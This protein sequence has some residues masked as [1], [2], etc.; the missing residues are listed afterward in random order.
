MSL[1]YQLREYELRMRKEG[2][3]SVSS[4]IEAVPADDALP[5]MYAMQPVRW[6]VNLKADGT[7]RD[8]QPR[9]SGKTK[10]KDLGLP[11]AAPELVRAATKAKLLMDNAEYVLGLARKEG[12]KNTL[13]RHEAFRAL[14]LAAAEATDEPSVRAVAT[15]LDGY[16][17]ET[18]RAEH[19]AAYPDFAPDTNVTFAV[20]G[21]Y[22]LDLTRV[23]QFWAE[24]FTDDEA[25]QA[26][27]LITGKFGPVMRIEPVK[28]KGIL[29]GQMAGMNFISAN[30]QAFESYG[31]R[32]S[33]IAPVRL[34][35]AEE[36]ARGLNRL[37]ADPN[38]S[39]KLGGVTYAF[40]T[41]E[42]AV[43]LVSKSLK[44]PP[45]GLSKY[46]AAKKREKQAR[47]EEVRQSLWSLLTGQLPTLK[48]GAAFYAAGFT[49]SGSRIAVRT[50]LS[51]TVQDAVNHLAD[52]FGAQSL[53]PI[54]PEDSKFPDHETFDL[55]ALVGAMYRDPSKAHIAP[56]V[57]A[58]MQF[59]LSGQPLPSVFLVRL[60]A[61]SRADT[62]RVTRPRAVLTKMVLLS[63]KE[64]G[65]QDD[66]LE[67]LDTSRP[68]PAYHLGRLLAVLDDIQSS[69][70]KANTTLVD[71]FYGAMSTTPYAVVGRLIQ[72]SQAHLQKLRKDNEG[73][74]FAKQREL[75]DVMTRL[76]DIPAKPLTTPQQ[77]L[78]ALGYYHQRAEI[79]A[80]I[81]ERS[82]AKKEREAA[83]ASTPAPHPTLLEGAN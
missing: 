62:N 63:R 79:S 69:V 31:L 42:G 46:G 48:A 51:S 43:P 47:T 70:M 36:Y 25:L 4:G 15:F 59:A 1:L 56:D 3:K 27:C 12:D 35:V 9:S 34:E 73:A 80:G 33:N 81:R 37:L 41:G 19:L 28:I 38:T 45:T 77:A 60:A 53:A 75:E 2:K 29:G 44:E 57:D 6:V 24:Q 74:Y 17:L 55:Y 67:A 5:F 40:W 8:V 32:A 78:F 26:E 54:N 50:H 21:E 66:H 16:D 76:R 58:L 72:G 64:Y 13:G 30:A 11:M 20:E 82:A 39:L 14:V 18:F 83:K 49:P 68:E 7:V 61:R 71:R 23:R 10:G 22:P 65:M 52:Y